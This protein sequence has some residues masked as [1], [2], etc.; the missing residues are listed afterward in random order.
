MA[1]L[2]TGTSPWGP[3]REGT[4]KVLPNMLSLAGTES[5]KY[6]PFSHS[7][8][9]SVSEPQT[10]AARLHGGDARNFSSTVSVQAHLFKLTREH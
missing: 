8:I 1:A 7:L 10:Q 3:L 4:L 2:S 5:D 6:P 9:P